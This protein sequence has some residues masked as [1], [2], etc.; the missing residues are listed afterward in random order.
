MLRLALLLLFLPF[1]ARAECA[2]PDPLAALA[3]DDPAAH[4]RLSARVAS[5]P[6]ADGLVWR[7]EF[8]GASSL[9]A[10]TLHT[11]PLSAQPWLSAGLERARLV[12]VEVA[13]DQAT[14]DAALGALMAEGF[15]SAAPEGAGWADGA[16]LAALI[17]A[18]TSRGMPAQIARQVRAWAVPLLLALP[19]CATGGPPGMD[20]ELVAAA[21]ARGVPVKGLETA[22]EQIGAFAELARADA[23][24]LARAV[25]EDDA[26][27]PATFALMDRLYAAGNVVWSLEMARW[28]A[29]EDTDQP[30][31][32]A[33][34]AFAAFEEAV[35]AR[36]NHLMAT[37]ATPE[38]R[39]GGVV[40][41]VGALHLPG[42]EGL[43]E[44]LRRE[45]AR[46]TRLD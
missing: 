17:P 20:A 34:R 21:M 38:L 29:V 15:L 11:A 33:A 8:G 37:R 44:L 18:L 4:A 27:A 26:E 9:M 23:V 2:G 30:R 46:V 1:A 7:V 41:A 36:R 39:R 5:T 16:D 35:I 13:A 14:E 3:R 10:G 45:G 32:A 6:N 12:M 19:G 24:A 40:L 42:P 31:A 28:A 43:I 22:A 25:I